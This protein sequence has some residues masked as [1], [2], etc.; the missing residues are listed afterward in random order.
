MSLVIPGNLSRTKRKPDKAVNNF[1]FACDYPASAELEQAQTAMPTPTGQ[2]QTWSSE[3]GVNAEAPG[4]NDEAVR[5]F[6]A[7]PVNQV[8]PLE[9]ME[10]DEYGAELG[11][12]ARVWKVYVKEADK[13]D[14]ELVEGWN[15]NM[16][17][18][19]TLPLTNP[20]FRSAALFSAV[21]SA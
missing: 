14:A 19:H 20:P 3:S 11:K 16:H 7:V 1:L 10:P 5:K 21:S 15:K 8:D 2:P 18:V 17:Y 9:L 4:T 13:W 12:E 6:R